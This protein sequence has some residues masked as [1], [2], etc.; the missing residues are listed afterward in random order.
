MLIRSTRPSRPDALPSTDATYLLGVNLPGISIESG[1]I[2]V[3][4][5]RR[6]YR[7]L[8]AS[9]LNTK[10][11]T[12][13]EL[14]A[15]LEQGDTETAGRIAHS[16]KSIAGVI[17]AEELSSAAA[18]LEKVIAA[19]ERSRWES[20]LEAFE[21]RLGVVIAGLEECFSRETQREV[22]AD[23]RPV[24]REVVQGIVEEMAGL[25]DRDMGRVMHL[26][27]ELHRQL[28][29]S[30]L[31]REYR[32]LEQRLDVFDIDGAKESLEVLAVALEVAGEEKNG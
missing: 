23:I 31:A 8:M 22:P 29:G 17:G 21:Q 6:L 16:M 18:A 30:S 19:G 5:N 10:R 20:S 24:N 15:G 1:L 28:A 9:F 27:D 12:G 13:H 2:R 32:C 11:E 3:N 4:G 7:E 14:R 26:R 25:L